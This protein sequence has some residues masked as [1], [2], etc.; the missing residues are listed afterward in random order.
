[1]LPAVDKYKHSN[2]QTNEASCSLSDKK[3][4]HPTNDLL[5]PTNYNPYPAVS[6][7]F[8]IS[9]GFKRYALEY[10]AFASLSSPIARK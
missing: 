3:L 1:M 2:R 10:A 7:F 6:S 5:Q 4:Y 8:S 9:A